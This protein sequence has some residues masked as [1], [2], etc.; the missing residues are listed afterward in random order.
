MIFSASDYEKRRC[1]KMAENIAT[2]IEISLPLFRA[3]SE[4]SRSEFVPIEA[5]A[6]DLNPQPILGNQWISS[7]LTV[8]KMIM[9][10]ECDKCENILEISCGSGY[11]AAVLSKIVNRVFTIERIERLVKEA[12][13]HFENLGISNVNVRYDDG[14]CGWRNFAPYERILIWAASENINDRLFS[15]LENGGIL[16][17]P[18]IKDDKQFITK[19]RKNINGEISEEIVEECEFVPLLSGRE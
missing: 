7:P 2:E 8:A 4:I 1:T 5:H 10:T 9:Q 13:K 17:A 18:I 15:Q 19:F 11:A 12:K 14:N 6:Y 3:L 16:L